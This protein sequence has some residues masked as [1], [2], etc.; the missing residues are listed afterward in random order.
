MLFLDLVFLASLELPSRVLLLSL[1]SVAL[2]LSTCVK[3]ITGVSLVTL[4]VVFV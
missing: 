1:L 3:V 4:C 2:S